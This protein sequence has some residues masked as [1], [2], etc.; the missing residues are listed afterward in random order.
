MPF[1]KPQALVIKNIGLVSF[2]I[3][4]HGIIV[5]GVPHCDTEG[6][7]TLIEVNNGLLGQ[8]ATNLSERMATDDEHVNQSTEGYYTKLIVDYVRQHLPAGPITNQTQLLP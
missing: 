8:A 2:S 4:S 5:Q 1:I 7:F 3:G 6:L